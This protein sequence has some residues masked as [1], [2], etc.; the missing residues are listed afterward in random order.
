MVL[1]EDKI[2]RAYTRLKGIK[3]N[4]PEEELIPWYHIRD[5]HEIIDSLEKETSFT[6]PEFRIPETEIKTFGKIEGCVNSFFMSKLDALLS[7]FEFKYLSEKKIE[8]GFKP[9]NK[10]E[11]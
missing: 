9:P 3:N 10:E 2:L 7:Y 1:D 4:L 11:E 6:L 5:Y 8:I